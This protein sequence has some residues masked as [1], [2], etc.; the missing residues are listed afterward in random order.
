MRTYTILLALSPIKKVLTLDYKKMYNTFV[1]GENE[2]SKTKI[3]LVTEDIKLQDYIALILIGEGYSVEAYASGKEMLSNMD[4][5]TFDLFIIDFSSPNVDGLSLCKTIRE[6][7]LLRQVPVIILLDD[8]NPLSKAKSIYSGADDYIEKSSLSTELLLRVKTSL[9][10]VYRYKDVNPLTKLPG[11][12]FALKELQ[13][14]IESKDD[15]AVGYADLYRFR[16]FNDK[17]G[18]SRGDKVIKYTGELIRDILIES[19]NS[20]DFLAHFGG[21]DFLFITLPDNVDTICS[22]IVN[23]FDNGI[24]SFYDPEDKDRKGIV[25]KTRK[26]SLVTYPILRISIG[27]LTN[28][29]Y[30]VTETAQVMQVTQELKDYAKKFDKSIYIKERRHSYPF[31]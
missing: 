16:R 26:G 19:G 5:K 31:Y 29:N 12:S 27:V 21:D 6:T 2:S 25:I 15:F 20:S 10:R 28:N 8:N 23:R 9:W 1:M 11:A 13:N 24:L 30:S 14:I 7:F 17:Y 4:K 3:L 22:E 18:F